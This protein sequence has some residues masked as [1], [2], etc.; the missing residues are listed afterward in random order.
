LSAHSLSR[1]LRFRALDARRRLRALARAPAVPVMLHH[2]SAVR[3]DAGHPAPTHATAPQGSGVRDV[4]HS[5]T[6]LHPSCARSAARGLDS[7]LCTALAVI[8]RA[9]GRTFRNMEPQQ[10]TCIPGVSQ[11]RPPCRPAASR[12]GRTR[13]REVARDLARSHASSRGR[14]RRHQVR[15]LLHSRCRP[16]RY[17]QIADAAARPM[18]VRGRV[19]ACC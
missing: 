8:R 2:C 10:S 4:A 14:V 5:P 13:S 9:P 11:I 18:R 1:V 7:R 16:P 3:P 19:L 17:P 15:P 6:D 12:R